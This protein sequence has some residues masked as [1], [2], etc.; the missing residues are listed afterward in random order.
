MCI[1]KK[2]LVCVR[3][4]VCAHFTLYLE[5]KV[6]DDTSE[7]KANQ[8]QV[9][10]NESSGGVGDLLDLFAGATGLTRFPN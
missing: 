9:G 8:E 10:E 6:R 5:G 3:V 2:P 1:P 7:S 4:C